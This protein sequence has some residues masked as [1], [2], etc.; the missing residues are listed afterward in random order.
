M[1]NFN[2]RI[3]ITKRF[4]LSF[5]IG[6]GLMLGNYFRMGVSCL[7]ESG[8]TIGGKIPLGNI[9]KTFCLIK[10]NQNHQNWK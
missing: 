6:Q 5:G 4:I 1:W 3:P 7:I 8:W 9:W 10:W 2:V